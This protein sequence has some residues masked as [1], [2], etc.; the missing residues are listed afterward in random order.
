M[1]YSI[2][3]YCQVTHFCR[4]INRH[5]GCVLY[6]QKNIENCN[7]RTDINNL[8]VQYTFECCA[9]QYPLDKKIKLNLICIYRSNN[10]NLSDIDLFFEKLSALLDLLTKEKINKYIIIGDF[11]ID[12]LKAEN[13]ICQNL[14]NI[15]HGFGAEVMLHEPTRE[16]YNSSSCLDNVFTNIVNGRVNIFQPHLSDHS[17]ISFSF[18]A[19]DSISNTTENLLK[20]RNFSQSN[21][22]EFIATLAE[23]NW[24][25]LYSIDK[26]EV[27][28]I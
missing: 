25:T 13:K 22:N 19:H 14:I 6:A 20:Y 10:P 8:S 28:N 2:P 21:I 3:N 24:S 7:I 26:E 12:F 9:V 5:G 11:N 18:D 23:I 16:T 17:A 1:C 4:P 27:N 15:L